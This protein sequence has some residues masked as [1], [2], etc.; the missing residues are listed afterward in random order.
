MFFVWKR[1]KERFGDQRGKIAV[2]RVMIENGLCIGEDGK[3]RCGPLSIGD[4]SVAKASEVD[5]RTVRATVESIR[6]DKSL[7]S[8]FSNIEPAGAMLGK[9]AHH[10]GFGVVELEASAATVGIVASASGLLAKSNI[11]IR[12]IYAKDPDLFENPTLTI[13]TARK[14]P[15][16]LMEKFRSIRGVKR[17]LLS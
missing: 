4:V 7:L 16:R 6:K 9:V 10:L 17:V 11:S 1:I 14:I 5:R 8:I 15:G 12:Q 3:I 2:A 13:I